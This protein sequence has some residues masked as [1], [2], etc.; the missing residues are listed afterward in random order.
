MT[1]DVGRALVHEA[2]ANDR[3]V[4]D[5]ESFDEGS[6][7]RMLFELLAMLLAGCPSDSPPVSG[8]ARAC[9]AG[10]GAAG[11]SWSPSMNVVLPRLDRDT[12]MEL[13]TRLRELPV[14]ALGTAL[15]DVSVEVT[16]SPVGGARFRCRPSYAGC[17]DDMVALRQAARHADGPGSGCRS[18]KDAR[19]A[20]PFSS[21]DDAAR[22][23]SHEEVWSY[24]TTAGY[25]MWPIWRFGA[26]GDRGGYRSREPEHVPADVVAAGSHRP[27]SGPHQARGG[28]SHHIMERPTIFSRRR[29]ARAI[30]TDSSTR[31]RRM[32]RRRTHALM[33]E[34]TKRF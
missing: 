32:K 27:G 7:G 29:L 19:P 6:V 25:W 31:R 26:E 9:A 13:L 12:A 1:F 5:P 8:E 21:P 18:S 16:Y 20:H 33:R 30:A 2:L 24:L 28:R 10:G 4:A 22:G 14:D 15:P 17:A 3:F 11:A 34:A 23:G